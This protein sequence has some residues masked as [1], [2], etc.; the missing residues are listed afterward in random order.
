MQERGRRVLAFVRRWV[1]IPRGKPGPG[2]ELPSLALGS[3]REVLPHPCMNTRT[4]RPLS[5]L[6]HQP[7][8]ERPA[9]KQREGTPSLAGKRPG[10]RAPLGRHPP[11]EA[12]TQELPSLALGSL[13]EVLPHPCMNTRT[14]RPFS[15]LPHQPLTER[16]AENI[17][18]LLRNAGKRQESPRVRA[19]LGRHP[20]WEARTWPGASEPCSWVDTRGASPPVHE[21]ED[22]PAL[23]LPSSSAVD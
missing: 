17:K 8:T 14:F 3:I 11:W 12:R 15:C 1:G 4:F 16:P 19:P 2:Q 22:F 9:E 10:V 21:H 18:G 7:L 20:P 5:C 13:R 23:F 6:P